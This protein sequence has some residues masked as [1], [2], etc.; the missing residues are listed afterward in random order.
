MRDLLVAQ[1]YL[2]CAVNNKGRI[3]GFDTDRQVCMTA[4]GLLQLQLAGCISMDEKTVS[5]VGELPPD[6]GYLKILYD[7][8]CKKSTVK[9]EK[10]ISDYNF[11]MTDKKFR[12][13]VDGIGESLE[14]MGLVMP[15]KSAVLRNDKGYLPSEDAVRGVI[16]KIRAELLEDG[17]ITE[18]TAALVILLHK[19]K[20]LKDYFSKYEQKEIRD[21][22][23]ELSKSPMGRQVKRLVDYV[24]NMIAVVAIVCMPH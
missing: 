14:A 23:T 22:L 19:A 6:M 20:I 15:A 13:L 4:S 10:L 21:K 2:I 1:E 17:E 7:D 12:A 5:A 11:A 9:L 24:E 3:S 16:E 8:I 18:D